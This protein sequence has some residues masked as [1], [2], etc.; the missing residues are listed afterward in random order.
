[1]LLDPSTSTSD[2]DPFYYLPISSQCH[3]SLENSTLT[4]FCVR[5]RRTRYESIFR[6]VVGNPITILTPPSRTRTITESLSILFSWVSRRSLGTWAC[7]LT[8]SSFVLLTLVLALPIACFLSVVFLLVSLVANLPKRVSS[9]ISRLFT[10][11]GS[12]LRK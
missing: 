8:R 4:K 12:T 5:S 7:V 11:T 1:M 3:T 9:V 6:L 10:T 2:Y